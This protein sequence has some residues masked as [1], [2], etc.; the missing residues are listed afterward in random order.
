MSKVCRQAS[1]CIMRFSVCSQLP[2][3]LFLP[4]C[5][6]LPLC[7]SLS[8]IPSFQLYFLL[9]LGSLVLSFWETYPSQSVSQRLSNK[10]KLGRASWE[11]PVWKP[12]CIG[13]PCKSVIFNKFFIFFLAIMN[14]LQKIL[15]FFSQ[16]QKKELS[17]CKTYNTV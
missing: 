2:L 9:W 4:L 3:S 8:F 1:E 17:M 6:C 5:L 13:V 12:K 7:P 11:L 10:S 15:L 16:W 14:F